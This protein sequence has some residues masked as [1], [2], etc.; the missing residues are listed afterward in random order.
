MSSWD[1]DDVAA[2]SGL[3][4]PVQSEQVQQEAAESGPYAPTSTVPRPPGTGTEGANGLLC[5]ARAAHA[6]G[7]SLTPLNGKRPKLKGWQKLGPPS[8]AEVE[9]WSAEGN[10]GVRTGSVSGLVVIDDDTPD[11][12]A[13]ERLGLPPTVTAITGGGGRHYYFA[14]PE[15]EL[16]SSV[17]KLGPGIDVRGEGG[18]V[19]LPGSVHPESGA[20]YRWLAGHGPPRP[21]PCTIPHPPLASARGT[22]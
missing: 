7:W 12:S 4:P 19:V 9:R 15:V 14:V 8:L 17:R 16:R 6:R 18:Q 13:A 22:A 11:Q 2:P 1:A 3:N 10:L 21:G 5:E 20:L